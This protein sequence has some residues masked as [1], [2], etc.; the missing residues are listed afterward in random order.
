MIASGEADIAL[1]GG[2]EA[3]LNLHPM[4]EL[5]MAGLSPSNLEHP[6][7]QNRPFDLWRT[8]G[9]IGEGAAIFILEHDESPRLGYAYLDGYG[10]GMDEDEKAPGGGLYATGRLA[11]AN[12]GVT[13]GEVDEI[14]AWGPGHR[15][16]DAVEAAALRRL[17]GERLAEIP[18]ASIKGALGNALAAA[19]PMQV[20]STA[21]G[22]R[23]G[24]IPPTVNWQ[25]PDPACPLNISAK[26]RSLKSSVVLVNSHGLSGTNTSLVLRR[27]R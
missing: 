20:A 12:A 13:V 26:A 25:F 14:S 15:L 11:L 6:E 22:M 2:T 24:F 23:K 27:C 21:I 1:C 9:V 3:P 17:F 18:T 5:T 10:F 19:G 16:I 4:L 8:T 7:R